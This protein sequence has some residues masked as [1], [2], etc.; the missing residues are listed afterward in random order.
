MIKLTHSLRCKDYPNYPGGYNVI[1]KV[2]IRRRQE[3]PSQRDVMMETGWGDVTAGS[4]SGGR[5]QEPRDADHLYKLEKAGKET[6]A[7]EEINAAD[8]LM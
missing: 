7:L 5:D 3:D 8:I 2:L 4:E 1:I 6:E